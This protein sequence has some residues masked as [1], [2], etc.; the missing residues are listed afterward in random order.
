[1][2]GNGVRKN[3]DWYEDDEVLSFI[4]SLL[5]KYTPVTKKDVI[6][7]F[8]EFIEK[9]AKLELIWYE[10]ETI[11]RAGRSPEEITKDILYPS[12]ENTSIFFPEP[13]EHKRR[14]PYLRKNGRN[15]KSHLQAH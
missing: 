2:A 13:L 7:A 10:W 8:K 4:Q 5:I 15:H 9:F 1:M 11:Y 14:K 12:H 3:K 6:T